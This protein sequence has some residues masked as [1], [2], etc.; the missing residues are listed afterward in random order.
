[1]PSEFEIEEEWLDRKR[2]MVAFGAKMRACGST[3]TAPTPEHEALGAAM[4]DQNPEERAAAC[5]VRAVIMESVKDLWRG[6]RDTPQIVTATAA[7]VP[8]AVPSAA[9]R[10]RRLFRME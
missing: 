10:H 2:A 1:M 4:E 9:K 8:S 3:F 5:R 6:L 7:E